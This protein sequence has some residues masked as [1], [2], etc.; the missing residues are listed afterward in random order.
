MINC[1]ETKHHH[2]DHSEHPIS[3]AMGS[4]AR[5]CESSTVRQADVD[6]VQARGCELSTVKQADVD[7]V[8]ARGFELSTVRQ[9]DADVLPVLLLRAPAIDPLV[10]DSQQILR[11]EEWTVV[12]ARENKK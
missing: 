9:A 7:V 1:N 4:V 5:G 8:Q 11:P 3:S 12:G 10:E 6:V 2:E